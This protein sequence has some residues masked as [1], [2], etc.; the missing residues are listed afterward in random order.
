METSKKNMGLDYSNQTIKQNLEKAIAEINKRIAEKNLVL[1]GELDSALNI[2]LENATRSSKKKL[3]RKIHYFMVSSSRRKMN[4]LLAFIFKRFLKDE[5][6]AVVKP[7]LKQQEIEKARKEFKKQ[8]A[9]MFEK[10]TAYRELKKKFKEEG[11]VYE[12]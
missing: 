2:D 6:K 9:V 7:S 10:K 11:G 1:E 3:A 5:K 8:L 12:N 4:V